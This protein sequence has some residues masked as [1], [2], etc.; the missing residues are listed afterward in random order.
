MKCLVL[1][2]GRGDRLWPLSRGHYPKQFIQMQHNHSLFQETIARN[3]PFCDEF[4]I[5]TN[6]E[7]RFIIEDQMKLFQ[8]ISYRCVFEEVGRGSM[9]AIMLSCMELSLSELVFVTGANQM[10]TGDDYKDAVLLAKEMAKTGKLV[11]FGMPVKKAEQRFGYIHYDGNTVLDFTEKPDEKTLARYEKDSSYLINTGMFLFQVGTIVSEVKKYEPYAY[12]A[13]AR[14]N[15]A[16]ENRKGVL[17]YNKDVMEKVPALSMEKAVFE[18]TDRAGVVYGTFDWKDISSLED[19]SSLSAGTIAGGHQVQHACE[20][21]TIINE[22]KRRLVVTSNLSNVTVV[23]TKDAVY[24]GKTGTSEQLKQ[25]IS[26]NEQYMPFFQDGRDSYRSWGTYELLVDGQNHRVKR[27]VI[28][29]GKTIYAHKHLY[30]N[31]CWTIVEGKAKIT[32]DG[33]SQIYEAGSCINIA[34]GVAHQVSNAGEIPLMVIEVSMGSNVTEDDMVSIQSRDLTDADL[35]YEIEP[36]VKLSPAYKDYLWGGQRLKSIYGK[37]CDYDILAESWEL[38]AHEAGQ[39]I[40]ATGRHK[41]SSFGEY[42]NTIGKERLGWKCQSLPDFP[43]LIKLIDAKDKLSVQ[44]HPDDEYALSC[45]NQYGK[46]EMWYVLDCEE[47]AGIYCGFNRDV[48]REEVKRR[49]ENNTI[50]EV[51]NWIPAKKGDVFFIKAGTVHA[52]GAGMMICEIQQSSNCTY[53]LYDYDRRD[54][55]GNLRQLHLDKALDVLDYR[56]YEMPNDTNTAKDGAHGFET[57]LPDT[58]GYGGKLLGRC[59]YFEC[60]DYQVEGNQEILLDPNSFVSIMCVAGNGSLCMG[61]YKVTVKV[62]DS[63]FAPAMEGKVLAQGNCELVVTH[64]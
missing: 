18:R 56:K 8:G 35:G 43:I 33:Q 46:N 7:Y 24:I 14:A 29:V 11:T 60:Y 39:S 36:F 10:V 4:I 26:E 57:L 30:R 20:N 3:I 49:I 31:E 63:V 28:R 9:A 34:A 19:L 59:K 23:N 25:I 64:V 42:L 22:C 53:R 21:V 61:D 40:V 15:S 58:F 16:R 1:A 52:I 48:T 27:I 17:F 32:L 50:L 41:G 38:S 47:G 37:Q 45:E 5:V 44:V 12:D 55:F 13:L 2:G 62:G 54:K 6:E 51:L